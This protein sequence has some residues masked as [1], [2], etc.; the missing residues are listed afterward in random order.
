M[1]KAG[2]RSKKDMNVF[3][4]SRLIN[5]VKMLSKD[6]ILLTINA[7]ILH[8]NL[9]RLIKHKHKIIPVFGLTMNEHRH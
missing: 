7:I 2:F 8:K 5:K 9:R 4:K 3:E 1:F 6:T